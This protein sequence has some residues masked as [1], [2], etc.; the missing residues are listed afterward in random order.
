M[1]FDKLIN[2][3]QTIPTN[4]ADLQNLDKY[5]SLL[6]FS[7]IKN[8]DSESFLNE[9]KHG[10]ILYTATESA[11]FGHFSAILYY[12]DTNIIELFDSYAFNLNQLYNNANYDKQQSKGINYLK[13]MI[14]YC[15]QRY[16]TKFIYNTVPLQNNKQQIQTCGK[17]ASLRIKM[18]YLTMKQFQN[19][20]VGNKL[21]NDM[22]V[23]YI[24]LFDTE[25]ND[26]IRNYLTFL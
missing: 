25:T 13:N 4:I 12:E 5:A 1:N 7:D 2:L 21:P 6:K 16:H 20:F 3:V 18:K 26:E 14:S 19:L 15:N 10:K 22:L 24:M 17:Y 23:S 8:M 9:I 11:V